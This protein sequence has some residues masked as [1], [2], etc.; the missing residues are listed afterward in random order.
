MLGEETMK[1]P[2]PGPTKPLAGFSFCPG[3][4]Y[5]AEA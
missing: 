5:R 1:P 4:A 3:P 2:L